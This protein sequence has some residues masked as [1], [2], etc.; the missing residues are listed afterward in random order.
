MNDTQAGTKTTKGTSTAIT[1]AAAL[2]R[3]RAAAATPGDW[4]DSGEVGHGYHV[5]SLDGQDNYRIAWTGDGGEPDEDDN[6][7]TSYQD[8]L[9]IALWGP[10]RARLLADWLEASDKAHPHHWDAGECPSCGSAPCGP[11]PD[12]ESCSECLD[13]Y[14]CAPVAPALELALAILGE[15]ALPVEP[16]RGFRV[17]DLVEI[18]ARDGEGEH[19]PPGLRLIGRTGVVAEIDD[20]PEYP[21]GISVEGWLGPV[22]CN[23]GEIRHADAGQDA[24]VETAGSAT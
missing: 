10:G 1:R 11:H 4:Y 16:P 20:N 23:S 22:W 7:D 9:L 3:E 17:L 18:T 24:P 12:I 15:T 8:M 6:E 13:D 21:I 5:D 14:P 2:I 19:T